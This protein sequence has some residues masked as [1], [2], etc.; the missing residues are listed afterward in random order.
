MRTAGNRLGAYSN[1]LSDLRVFLF[2]WSK[3]IPFEA[4]GEDDAE[5]FCSMSPLI[6]GMGWSLG[7]QVVRAY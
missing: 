6:S 1:L 4:V 3:Q 2:C 7:E 5:L